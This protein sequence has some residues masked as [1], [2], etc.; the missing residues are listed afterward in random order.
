[1]RHR[2]YP[3]EEVTRPGLESE[4]VRRL[5]GDHENGESDDP[6]VTLGRVMV[7]VIM[8]QKQVREGFEATHG[9]LSR[10]EKLLYGSAGTA[11]LAIA[12]YVAAKLGL[13]IVP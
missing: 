9:R 4:P 7:E 5:R 1:M 6:Y 12:Q 10:L 3:D 2:S 11:V 13:H 8:L